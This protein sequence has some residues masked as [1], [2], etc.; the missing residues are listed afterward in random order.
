[1]HS[2]VEWLGS[3]D[4][5]CPSYHN[6]ASFII[7]VSCGEY[8]DNT[9]K[10]VRAIDNG[11]NDI[12]LKYNFLLCLLHL[13]KTF[14]FV[15][16]VKTK[17]TIINC[18]IFYMVYLRRECPQIKEKIFHE[19]FIITKDTVLRLATLSGSTLYWDPKKYGNIVPVYASQ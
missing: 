4:L 3:L 18:N 17:K 8:G 11:K 15:I 6:P 10:L 5:Q 19:V 14:V 7:E 13:K 9:G 16:L 12:R 2:T 1:M